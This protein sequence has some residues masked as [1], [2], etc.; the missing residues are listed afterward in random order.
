[1]FGARLVDN[2]QPYDSVLKEDYVRGCSIDGDSIVIVREIK[3]PLD[4]RIAM[5]GFV[6]FGTRS[7]Q[8][9]LSPELAEIVGSPV[10]TKGFCLLSLWEYAKVGGG[11][12]WA[13]SHTGPVSM[14]PAPDAMCTRT[15][16]SCAGDHRCA[17]SSTRATP[18]G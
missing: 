5:E 13:C 6:Y 8:M 15:V 1:M 7:G 18:T 12:V 11:M 4:S 10:A 16:A 14:R 2:S 3:A 17:S 9:L